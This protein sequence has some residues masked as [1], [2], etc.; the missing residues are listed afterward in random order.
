[1]VDVA[2]WRPESMNA[3][4]AAS[5]YGC[6]Q[7]TIWDMHYYGWL[8]K[9][10]TDQ[11]TVDQDVKANAAGAQ[12]IKSADGTMPVIIGEYGNSTTGQSIDANGDQVIR[13]VQNSG[14]GSAAWWY[15]QGAPGD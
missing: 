4:L 7:N 3:N 11:S 14:F 15:D 13:A 8:T 6:M 12:R 10:N 5:E 2:G 1:M 9:F